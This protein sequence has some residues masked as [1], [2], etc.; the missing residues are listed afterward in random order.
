MAAPQGYPSYSVFDSL[1]PSLE[2]ALLQELGLQRQCHPGSFLG[3]SPHGSGQ[4][5]A[6]AGDWMMG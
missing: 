1:R 4:W 6:T 3:Q 2:L 5:E